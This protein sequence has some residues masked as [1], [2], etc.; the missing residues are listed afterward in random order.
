MQH[1]V[2]VC[3]TEPINPLVIP[4]HNLAALPDHIASHLVHEAIITMVLTMMPGLWELLDNV[5]L[6]GETALL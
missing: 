3:K 5:F 6:I 4:C 1:I 2:D